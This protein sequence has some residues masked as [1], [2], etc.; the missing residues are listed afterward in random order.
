MTLFA[1]EYLFREFPGQDPDDIIDQLAIQ[2]PDVDFEG[3]AHK[4][5]AIAKALLQELARGSAPEASIAVWVL[6]DAALEQH[7]SSR[8][9]QWSVF[10][11]GIVIALRVDSLELSTEHG[12]KVTFNN[13][14]TAAIVEMLADVLPNAIENLGGAI[15]TAQKRLKQIDAKSDK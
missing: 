13:S 2:L 8:P 14:N 6:D 4:L 12:V 9:V 3:A 1:R 10:W 7:G 5:N 11:V 15:D